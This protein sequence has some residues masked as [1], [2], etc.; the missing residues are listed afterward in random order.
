VSL[1]LTSLKCATALSTAAPK[2]ALDLAKSVSRCKVET[3]AADW[4][5]A[6]RGLPKADLQDIRSLSV[7]EVRKRF[8]QVPQVLPGLQ[9]ASFLQNLEQVQDY[10]IELIMQMMPD[11]HLQLMFASRAP[12]RVGVRARGIGHCAVAE[13]I[14]SQGFFTL[15]PGGISSSSVVGSDASGNVLWYNQ[16]VASTV[17][18]WLTVAARSMW[19]MGQLLGELLP[20]GSG[21]SSGGGGSSG[22]GSSSGGGGGGSSSSS[23]GHPQ[24]T[25]VSALYF[26]NLQVGAFSCCEW[27]GSQLSHM[28]L[29]GDA[30]PLEGSSSGKLIYSSSSSSSSSNGRMPEGSMPLLEH[31]LD[32]HAQ[33][34]LATFTALQRCTAEGR[35][36]TVKHDIKSAVAAALLQHVWGDELPGQLRAFGAAVAAVLPVGWACNNAACTNLGKLSELQLVTGK[37]KVC[38]GCKQV[39]MC[40]A[41]CQ[42]Q[43]WK[44]GHKLVCKKLAAAAAKAADNGQGD[45]I[46][47]S[48]TTAASSSHTAA[49]SRSTKNSSNQSTDGSSSSSSS[50]S[51]ISSQRDTGAAAAP[52][53]L[54]TTAAGAAALSLRQ[55]KELL[56]LT[57]VA[58][59]AGAV[60]NSDL[61]QLLVGYLGLV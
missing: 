58:G 51:D 14:V 47:G 54:P 59:V 12:P 20:G 36:S 46:R 35:P 34:Q 27:I 50:S 37:A 41:E 25:S 18:P 13:E 49:G 55:L 39:H 6:P 10:E 17:I 33:L 57:G 40:S 56:R 42:K 1:L 8:K 30:D 44:A 24:L 9:D 3:A 28:H 22:R 48:S 45:D 61:V 32:Q 52:L 21:N 23:S 15:Q 5:H 26:N 31:L 11:E 2:V 19:L 4:L 53:K 60:E 38:A 29:P 43:H 7:S 16:Q